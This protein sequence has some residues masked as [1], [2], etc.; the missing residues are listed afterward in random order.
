M[1]QALVTTAAWSLR[2]SMTKKVNLLTIRKA[3]KL[4]PSQVGNSKGL[5]KLVHFNSHKN[6][7]LVLRNIGKEGRTTPTVSVTQACQ[8]QQVELSQLLIQGLTCL[9]K[10][11]QESQL[12]KSTW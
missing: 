11:A 7:H 3:V 10:K 12:N 2:V 9:T 6:N 8:D 4:L 1:D 5:I